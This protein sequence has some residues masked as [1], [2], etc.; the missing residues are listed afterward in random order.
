[1]MKPL[2]GKSLV[3]TRL[4]S[5]RPVGTID[6]EQEPGD[7]FIEASALRELLFHPPNGNQ[8]GKSGPVRLGFS[9]DRSGELYGVT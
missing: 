8:A 6:P 7:A 4:P 3:P 1:M 5:L 2:P 9:R